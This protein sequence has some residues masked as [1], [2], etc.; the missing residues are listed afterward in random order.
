MSRVYDLVMTH[1]L[2]SDDFFIHRI[3]EYAAASS[4]NFFLIE[5]VWIEAFSH[6]YAQGKIWARV[7]L[8]MHSEH[9][10]PEEN[11]HQLVWQMHHR[12][13]QVID[14]PDVAL[15]AFDKAHLHPRLQ[16]AGLAVP[17]TVIVPQE[18]I[19]GFELTEVERN[20]IGSPFVIKPSMGYGRHGVQLNVTDPRDL[21][22]SSQSWP[23]PHYLLQKKIVPRMMGEQPAYFRVYFVFGSL[24]LAWWNCF[25]D[26]YREVSEEEKQALQLK[27]LEEIT[28]QIAQLTGM[29]FFSTEI[30]QDGTGQ[31]VVIDYV[32]DQCHLLTQS[33]NPSMGVPDAIVSGIAR[34][35]VE[36]VVKLIRR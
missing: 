12:G 14:P 20:L 32:N 33:S 16:A 30:A 34:K 11:F 24:W 6:L 19:A 29:Q 26:R 10:R 36:S 7:L 1:K 35:L 18:K 22:R 28:R 15:A 21:A 9:H 4:L 5:P 3:Q 27:P 13:T 17:P 25:T 8:N 2:D 31:F 23:N